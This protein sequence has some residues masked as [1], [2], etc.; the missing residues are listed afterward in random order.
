MP[1]PFSCRKRRGPRALSAH[2]RKAPCIASRY[3]S[4][5]RACHRRRLSA[6]GRACQMVRAL[7]GV[8]LREKVRTV[9]ASVRPRRRAGSL[10]AQSAR[11]DARPATARVARAPQASASSCR[12][13]SSATATSWSPRRCSSAWRCSSAGS[14][15]IHATCCA[16]SSPT[17]ARS[18]ALRPDMTPQIARVVSTRLV[19]L[20][21]PFRVRYE[22]TV[23][24]R[25]RGRAR[26]QRQIAQVGIELI[27]LASAEADVEVIRID[28]R[29]GARGRP[30]RLSHRA[31][32]G[33]RRSRA[34]LASMA[35]RCSGWPPSPGAARTRRGCSS[36]ST[37]QA[38]SSK[39]RERI[40]AVLHLHGDLRVLGEAKRARAPAPPA[41]QHVDEPGAC[42]AS[43]CSTWASAR[44]S[45]STWARSAAPATTRASASR[46]SH[47]VPAR[48][49]RA[50][51]ATTSC[52]PATASRSRPPG[53]AI[54]VENLLWALD[55]AGGTWRERGAVRFVV[56]GGEESRLRAS[57]DAGAGRGLCRPRRCRLPMPHRRA[58]TRRAWSIDC[59]SGAAR[60]AG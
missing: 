38:S 52:S 18:S 47:A 22:G 23:I 40:A 45:A 35:P 50:A 58:P 54:D 44:S 21:P 55:H 56:A 14:R 13:S 8:S 24:R 41:A 5:Q 19:E 48:P 36:C 60:P 30:E 37:Q 11:R 15:S 1:R 25:R 9:T 43:C 31:V 59:D 29:G 12:P 46:C 34:A 33:G 53:A 7:V 4:V 20:P 17:A 2:R 10:A 32:G 49:W 26:R 57:A 6:C 27:G 16:S 3:R 39:A 51:V 42:G 28:R